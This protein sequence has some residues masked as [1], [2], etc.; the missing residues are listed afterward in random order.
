MGLTLASSLPPMTA[1]VRPMTDDEFAAFLL[2]EREE[3]AADVAQANAMPLD[4]ALAQA[5]E[6]LAGFLPEGTRTPGHRLLVVLDGDRPIGQLWTGPHPRRDDSAYVYEIVIDES[7]RGKG[8]GRDAM[9]AAEE[10]AKADGWTSIGLNVFGFNERAQ[11]LY[12]SL[13][14]E[15]ASIQMLKQLTD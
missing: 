12:S 5:D 13:G 10:L 9:L 8:Y 11:R 15:V 3:Y 14:Y 4:A 7:E 2:R 6:Q 1:T